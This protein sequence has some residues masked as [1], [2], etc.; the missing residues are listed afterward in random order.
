MTA[1]VYPGPCAECDAWT[2]AQAGELT[3][4]E[5]R[6]HLR[7]APCV[8][9]ANG[10]TVHPVGT[11]GARRVTL[12]ARDFETLFLAQGGHY[13]GDRVE[14]SYGP[15]RLVALLYSHAQVLHDDGYVYPCAL[16]QLKQ[17]AA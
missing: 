16:S 8:V 4:V 1:N 11:L 2:T 10:V 9:A 12:G 3:R 14:S 6:W 7:C 17:R 5:G 13:L 15:G